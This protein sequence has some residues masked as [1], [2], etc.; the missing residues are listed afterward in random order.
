[1]KN[2]SLYSRML[3]DYYIPSLIEGAS[4][5]ISVI[6]AFIVLFSVLAVSLDLLRGTQGKNIKQMLVKNIPSIAK[7]VVLFTFLKNYFSIFYMK[8]FRIGAYVIPTKMTGINLESNDKI[9]NLLYLPLRAMVYR[10]HP[11]GEKAIRQMIK[12][13]GEYTEIEQAGFFKTGAFAIRKFFGEIYNIATGQTV[14]YLVSFLVMF[15][16]GLLIMFFVTN[17]LIIFFIERLNIAIMLAFGI[18]LTIGFSDLGMLKQYGSTFI[19]LVVNLMVKLALIS[20]IIN[21][22]IG[23]NT[24]FG[25][26]ATTEKILNTA[27][28]TPTIGIIIALLGYGCLLAL[29]RWLYSKMENINF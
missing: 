19:K 7:Y 22:V 5:M 10:M 6:V 11:N 25:V 9:K 14:G 21:I 3:E 4:T 24:G 13:A 12:N 17:I 8:L 18:L 20:I 15:T 1:M 28:I 16:L 26:I 27:G 29:A 23:E 2:E